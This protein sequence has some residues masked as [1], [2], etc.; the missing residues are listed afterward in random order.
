MIGMLASILDPDRFSKLILIAPSPRYINDDDY[1]GGFTQESIEGLLNSLDSD[2]LSW[3]HT[4]APVI[5][6]NPNSPEL[7]QELTRLFCQSNVEI[8]KDFARI[9]FLSDS[10][11]DLCNVKKETLILQCSEDLIAPLS[12]G[13]YMHQNMVNSTF[14]LLNATGHCPNLS[15]PEETIAAMKEYLQC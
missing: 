1:I 3:S 7:G 14:K 2:Y 11:A 12:V 4:M 9:T 13:E 6:G 10:R 8:A 15:A 5:M